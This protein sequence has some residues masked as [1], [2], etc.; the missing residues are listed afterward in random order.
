VPEMRD[1]MLTIIVGVVS[2]AMVHSLA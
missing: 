1:F 2:L